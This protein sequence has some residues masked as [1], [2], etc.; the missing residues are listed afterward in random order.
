MAGLHLK[1][2]GAQRVAN[3]ALLTYGKIF[4]FFFF[5]KYKVAALH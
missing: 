2:G 1:L 4:L 3:I 5:Y